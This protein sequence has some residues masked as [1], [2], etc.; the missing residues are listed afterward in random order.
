MPAEHGDIGSEVRVLTAHKP[1][2]LLGLSE[3][4]RFA[5]KNGAG[6]EW[7]ELPCLIELERAL[8]REEDRLASRWIELLHHQLERVNSFVTR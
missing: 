2:D 1:S 5:C 8:L 6:L 3:I 4:N 7:D